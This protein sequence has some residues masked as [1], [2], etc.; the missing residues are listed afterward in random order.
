MSSGCCGIFETARLLIVSV[1]KRLA[2]HPG[3]DGVVTAAAA[4][5]RFGR[6]SRWST[7]IVTVTGW[8]AIRRHCHTQLGPAGTRRRHAIRGFG[9]PAP[10]DVSGELAG[11]RSLPEVPTRTTASVLLPSQQP[12]RRPRRQLGSC[13][14]GLPD[15]RAYAPTR[16]W[17]RT[18]VALSLSC[19]RRRSSFGVVPRHAVRPRSRAATPHGVSWHSLSIDR[20]RR[21][22]RREWMQPSRQPQSC[23]RDRRRKTPSLSWPFPSRPSCNSRSIVLLQRHAFRYR[24]RDSYILRK[25][26]CLPLLAKWRVTRMFTLTPPQQQWPVPDAIARGRAMGLRCRQR[27]APVAERTCAY[28]DAPASTQLPTGRPWLVIVTDAPVRS[29]PAKSPLSFGWAPWSWPSSRTE[30]SL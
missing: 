10:E 4:D 3:R 6:D 28:P 11:H 24:N 18:L 19:S 16:G 5:Y 8:S 2:R 14:G 20:S 22:L 26:V 12:E 29:T 17:L 25:R 27:Q 30:I 7:S 23:R 9:R 1:P 15:N 21:P 13:R